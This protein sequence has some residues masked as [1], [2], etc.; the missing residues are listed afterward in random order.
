MKKL[1]P[2]LW[3]LAAVSCSSQK[4]TVR[5]NRTF[6]LPA[7]QDVVMYQVNPRLYAEKDSF[8]AML[9][10]LDSIQ[11]LGA[12]VVWFMPICE[13]GIEKAVKSPYC[14]K[15]YTNTNPEFGTIEEFSKLVEECHKRGMAV[16]IDWV[17]NHTSWDNEWIST[18][19]E[20]YTHNENGE[21]IHPEGTNW[22]DVADLNFDNAQMRQAMIDAMKFWV[23]N[24]GIDGF[25]CDAADYVPFDFWKQCCDELRAIEGKD[26]LLLAEGQRK[27]HFDAGFDMNYAWAYIAELRRIFN[28]GNQ[29]T[30]QQGLRPSG[31]AALFYSDSTEYAGVPAGKVKLRFTTNHD[32]S[33]KMSPVREFHGERGSMA[34]FVATTY[35]HGGMLI[36][37]SQEVAYPGRINFFNYTPVD[38][39]ANSDIYEEY[40]Q[41]VRIYNQNP[42]IRKGSITPYPDSRVLMFEREYN[43]EKVFVVVNLSQEQTKVALPKDWAGK[44]CTDLMS[45]KKIGLSSDRQFLKPFEYII[46]K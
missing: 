14:V 6:A 22:A 3:I 38:W 41:L 40:K 8:N 18:N 9:T 42:A 20:W 16:I 37:G 15:D 13:I 26:L 34:A 5:S 25:R 31:A 21:I 45:G 11:E 36:Y 44:Q 39:S 7:P 12:N 35:I 23:N 29:R 32:E 46:V 43:G 28:G 24:V 30:R 1:L 2:I 17:A 33:D 19:P 10:H 4:D 27:D